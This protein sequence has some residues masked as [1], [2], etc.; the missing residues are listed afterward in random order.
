[1]FRSQMDD[2]KSVLPTFTLSVS[3]AGSE[4]R[5][6]TPVVF[7]VVTSCV[8]LGGWSQRNITQDTLL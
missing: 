7:A 8:V 2:L 4:S 1:M 6:L 5:R 3:L